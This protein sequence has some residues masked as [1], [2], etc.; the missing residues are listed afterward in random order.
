M[1]IQS[2]SSPHANNSLQS[3][4]F[5]ADLMR[6]RTWGLLPQIFAIV[7]RRLVEEL[8]RSCCIYLWLSGS[9]IRS[10]RE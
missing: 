6:K 8:V 4:G 5:L 3:D 9:A 1:N 7:H 10:N 2:S